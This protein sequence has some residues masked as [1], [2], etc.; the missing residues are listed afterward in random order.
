VTQLAVI[1]CDFPGLESAALHVEWPR[2]PLLETLLA[3]AQVSDLPGD[4]R[5]WLL[6]SAAPAELREFSLA[7][8]AGAGFRNQQ[9]TRPESTGYWL[10]TPVHFFAG[11]DSLQI[12][13]SGLLTLSEQEQR[14][15]VADF[16]R[17]F[18]DS[19][20]RLE[21]F[22]QRELLL[23]GLQAE[24]DGADPMLFVGIDPRPGLPRGDSA[25]SLRRLGSEIEMWLHEHPVNAARQARGELAATALWF[26]GARAPVL[27]A[28][29]SGLHNPRL[30]GSDI[31]AEALWRLQHRRAESLSMALQ[32]I[33][34]QPSRARSD[35]VVLYRGESELGLLGS[36]STLEQQWLPRALRV[37]RQRRFCLRLIAGRRL[38][39]VSMMGMGRIW[40]TRR[41]WWELLT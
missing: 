24:A 19:P 40:R 13:P 39:S 41:P 12:H 25:G 14:T 4:W 8:I 10:A 2:L 27:P 26:W 31:Y 29:A 15:L 18:S 34:P 7:A 30:F 28:S 32:T 11:L 38:Y 17:V 3:R 35:S 5:G 16:A 1:L 36:L 9:P 33:S 20:W 37:L 21:S 23:S 6:A 22:G